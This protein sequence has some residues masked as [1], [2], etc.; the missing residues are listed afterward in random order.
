MRNNR[1]T[2]IIAT[3]GPASK[4]ADIINQLI[5]SGV[6]IFRFNLKHNTPTGHGRNIDEVRKVA[7]RLGR[8]VQVLIDLPHPSFLKGSGLVLEKKPDYVALSH[9]KKASDVIGFKK[10]CKK[11]KITTNVIAKIE[12]NESLNHFAK[13][14]NKTDSIMIARGDLG[15]T[16]PIEQVPFVQKEIVLACNESEK[17]VIVA[18]EMLLSMVSSKKPTRAE[19]SDVAN[20][21]LEG[22]DA[23]MLSEETA[24]GENPVEAVRVMNKIIT[25]A[26][27]W[28]KLGHLHIF[29]VKNKKFKFGDF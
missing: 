5:Q 3:V 17:M 14:L 16:I 29:S 6:D 24:I 15:K 21:V 27:S 20:A 22:S 11:N 1:K 28:K 9:V 7:Q 8:T 18:T 19:A 26:E 23:V 4:K 13:I 12:T 2:K 10:I 25:E